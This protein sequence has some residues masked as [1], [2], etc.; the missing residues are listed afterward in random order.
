MS[1]R[2]YVLHG[3]TTKPAD[4]R[5]GSK[6]L[7]SSLM[8]GIN[9][10]RFTQQTRFRNKSSS[11]EFL[12]S[13]LLPHRVVLVPIG[14]LC[15]NNKENEPS[16]LKG[17]TITTFR[18]ATHPVRDGLLALLGEGV[19][20]DST[21][22]HADAQHVD[23]S[24]LTALRA[25]LKWDKSAQELFSCTHSLTHSLSLPHPPSSLLTS[26]QVLIPLITSLMALLKRVPTSP[27]L[28]VYVGAAP[29]QSATSTEWRWRRCSDVF[30]LPLSFSLLLPLRLF[31]SKRISA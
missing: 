29:A 11:R 20:E 9:R 30:S 15:R 4:N 6:T 18:G 28:H 8:K 31:C 26:Q 12:T 22:T 5:K 21:E 23:R 3:Q 1:L 7:N 10:V 27:C 2:L 16:V 13:A 25:E 24:V 14:A 19:R 17:V